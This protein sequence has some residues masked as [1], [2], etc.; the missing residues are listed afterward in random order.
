MKFL[1]LDY[2]KRHSRID[3][4]CEDA[5]LELYGAA[6]E[7][8]VLSILN[9]SLFDLKEACGGEVPAPVR[10]AALMLTDNSYQHRS[11]SEVSNLSVVP[12]GIDML[13]KPYIIL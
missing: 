5:E 8:T 13:L 2:I 3:Y 12:Y 10:Q 6:A 1:T 9:R 4:D 7:D 11:P